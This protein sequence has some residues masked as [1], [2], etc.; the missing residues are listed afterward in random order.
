MFPFTTELSKVQQLVLTQLA[1]G[2][3]INEAAAAAGVHRNTIANWRRSSESFRNH[4]HTMQ[5]EQAMHW[6]DEMQSLAPIAIKTLQ[7][8]LIDPK[9]P[10]T[11]RLRAALA[12]LDKVATPPPIQPDLHKSAQAS[13]AHGLHVVENMP[14]V[15]EVPIVHPPREP[16]SAQP[17]TTPEPADFVEVPYQPETGADFEQLLADLTSPPMRMPPAIKR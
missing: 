11:V 13:P 16:V 15:E 6:R 8:L 9:T 17:C 12:V 2:Q 3:T 1:S 4:W 7:D 14:P 10:P 5:Y